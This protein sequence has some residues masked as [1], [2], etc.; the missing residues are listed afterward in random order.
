[1][2]FGNCLQKIGIVIYFEILQIKLF[3]QLNN[4]DCRPKKENEKSIAVP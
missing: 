4:N 1:M 3:L 2:Y